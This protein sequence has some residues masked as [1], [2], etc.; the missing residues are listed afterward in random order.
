[1]TG[2]LIGASVG[3]LIGGLGVGSLN[4]IALVETMSWKWNQFWTRTTSRFKS[5]L[6]VGLIGGLSVGQIGGSI[7]GVILALIFGLIDRQKGWPLVQLICLGLIL[8]RA[9]KGRLIPVGGRKPTRQ[10]TLQPESSCGGEGSNPN[11]E[12]HDEKV[13]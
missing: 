8:G 11:V 12:A 1:L 9:M 5:G 7:L 6:Y 13:P 10:L 2:G 3:A 4:H